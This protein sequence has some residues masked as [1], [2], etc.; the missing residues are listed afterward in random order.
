[1][2]NLL[3]II[4]LHRRY[5]RSIFNSIYFNFH[6]LPFRQAI[7]L[8]ILLYKPRFLELKG[9]VKLSSEVKF[10]MVKL[11][12]PVV[13]I[14]PNSG[15]MI[16]NH[17]GTIVFHGCCEIGNNSFISVGNNGYCEFGSKFE[18]TTSLKLVCYYDI[19]IGDRCSMGWDCMIMDTDLHKLTKV[20]GGYTQGFAPI[21]IGANNWFGNGCLI[22]KRTETPD[23]CTISARTILSG[24]VDVPPYSIIGQKHDVELIAP[25]LWRNMD[26]DVITYS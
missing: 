24:K 15:I 16:E 12:S 25:G 8:P 21:R 9:N 13:S 23:Y 7:H 20:S 22:M 17:G 2:K 19:K 26:D 4:W 5:L 3:K 6:Y 14:Y 18:A 11:G 1:M 10:G